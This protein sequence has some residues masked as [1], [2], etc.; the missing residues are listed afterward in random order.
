MPKVER[1]ANVSWDGN[2]ARGDGR[3]SADTGAFGELPFSLPTRVGQAEG[4]TSPEELLAAAHAGCLAMSLAG[5]LTSAGT[6]PG[7]LD[8]HATIR[9]DE[10]P[11]RGH[12]IVGS[13]VTIRGAVPG[14]AEEPWLEAVRK[15]DEGCTFSALLRDAGAEISLDA[16]LEG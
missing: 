3:I 7:K 14:L 11:G 10:R 9:L 2:L 4:K 6:P 5:E 8:V 15:A 16:R 1:G 13:N 12:L